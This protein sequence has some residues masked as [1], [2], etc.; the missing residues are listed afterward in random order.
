M[1]PDEEQPGA[2]P[3]DEGP[4][5]PRADADDALPP[6]DGAASGDQADPRELAE[7]EAA[8]H[9]KQRRLRGLLRH[10]GEA[11]ARRPQLPDGAAL[12]AALAGLT[13]AAA[14]AAGAPHEVAPT[15]DCAVAAA[16]AALEA[17]TTPAVAGATAWVD[18]HDP[19]DDDGLLAQRARRAA[20]LIGSTSRG[21]ARRGVEVEDRRGAAPGGRPCAR[22]RQRSHKTGAA[23]CP[24]M[25]LFGV[26]NPHAYDRGEDPAAS[27]PRMGGRRRCPALPNGA[28]T[29]TGWRTRSAAAA[30]TAAACPPA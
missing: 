12:D 21:M 13:A 1:E 23:T 10:V 20:S 4:H 6:G 29:G 19:L 16:G 25:A 28:S 30:H 7:L 22:C 11:R 24:A 9:L 17:A 15:T 3:Q 5:G 26:K 8:V 27:D 14:A 18:A 2:G